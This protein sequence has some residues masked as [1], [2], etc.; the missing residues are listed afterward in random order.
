MTLPSTAYK[1]FDQMAVR[2]QRAIDVIF[3]TATQRNFSNQIR[4]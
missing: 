2:A 4:V 1:H 3:R